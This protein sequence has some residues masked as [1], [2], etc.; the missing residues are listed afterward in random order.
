[1]ETNTPRLT[2]GCLAYLD[3]IASGLVP[4]KVIRI[5]EDQRQDGKPVPV[6]VAR[7]TAARPGYARGETLTSESLG[8]I[9]PRDAVK[10][11]RGQVFPRI[12]PFAIGPAETRN[13]LSAGLVVELQ[14]DPATIARIERVCADGLHMVVRGDGYVFRTL[15]ALWRPVNPQ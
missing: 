8:R 7:V 5:L 12:L 15:V 14:N 9:V 13:G 2:V 11:F 6:V 1:M 4:L 10:R 3:T